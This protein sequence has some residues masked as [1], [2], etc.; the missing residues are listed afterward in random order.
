MPEGRIKLETKDIREIKAQGKDLISKLEPLLKGEFGRTYEIKTHD[1]IDDKKSWSREITIRKGSKVGAGVEVDYSDTFDEEHIK[2]EVDISTKVG[3]TILYI[4]TGV[5]MVVGVILG[6]TVIADIIFLGTTIS[7]VL[8]GVLGVIIGTTL[9][10]VIRKISVSGQKEENKQLVEQ[11][12]QF[13]SKEMGPL[14]PG[15]F[16]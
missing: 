16:D 5:F 15:E 14:L 2:I 7:A 11:V 1:A 6:I 9:G 13:V 4:F 3:K 8:G 10:Y 12:W